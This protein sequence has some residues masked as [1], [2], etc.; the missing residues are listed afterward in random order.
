MFINF[1]FLIRYLESFSRKESVVFEIIDDELPHF[2]QNPVI[3][4][5]QTARRNS[6]GSMG[7]FPPLP[8]CYWLENIPTR[9]E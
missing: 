3:T 5:I 2:A 8:D 1:L 4:C 7:S 6:N 9:K